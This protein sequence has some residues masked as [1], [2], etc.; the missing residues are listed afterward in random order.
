MELIYLFYLCIKLVADYSLNMP[1]IFC[2]IYVF[3]YCFIFSLS[4]YQSPTIF[5]CLPTL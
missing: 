5:K 3:V 1:C 2:L 4:L